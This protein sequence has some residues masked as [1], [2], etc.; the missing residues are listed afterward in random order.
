VPKSTDAVLSEL[1][2]R[3]RKA[4]GDT[5]DVEVKSA[6]GGLPSNVTSSLCA[7]ANLPGGGWLILGLDEATGFRPVPLADL[8]LLKQGLASKARSCHPPITLEIEQDEVDGMPIVITR[9]NECATSAKPCRDRAAGK[10]WIRSWDGDYT[11]SLLEEQAFLA[12]RE[13]PHFDRRPVA[14]ASLDD[15][16]PALVD[17]WSQTATELDSTGLGRFA[18]QEQLFRAGIINS[19][20]IPTKAG[21]LALGRYPQ[22][23]FPRYVVNMA[24]TLDS[25]VHEI[26]ARDVVTVSGPIPV[27][28]DAALEWARK[29]FAKQVI[30]SPDGSVHDVWEYPLE[31]FR[32]LVGNGLVHRDLDFWSEGQ[33]VEVRLTK[34][35]LIVTNPGGLYGVTVDRLG[36]PGTTSARNGR[37]IEICKYVRSANGARVVE[38]LASGIPKVFETLRAAGHPDP[39]FQDMGINFTVILRE[40]RLAQQHAAPR[41][42]NSSEQLVLTSLASAEMS[43]KELESRTGIKQPTI[44]KA[45]R[46]L[47]NMGLTEQHGGRGKATTYSRTASS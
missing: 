4:G 37:L 21:L 36:R 13:Q 19:D 45:L 31:A 39:S 18:G 32:E 26:R 12:Q 5:A 43:V 35:R 1:L 33:A 15:L 16:D 24:A 22:Q 46:S 40:R 38:T 41:D 6:T 17:V 27:M 8:Q 11:M 47:A 42:L 14:G 20:G 28:L 10:A 25:G 34:D 23:Y 29:A 2:D 44:R 9:V 3:L 30:S 7:L